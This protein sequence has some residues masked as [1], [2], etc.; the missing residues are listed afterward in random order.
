[1]LMAWANLSYF[2][3]NG[4]LFPGARE[5]LSGKDLHPGPSSLARERRPQ[6]GAA[7]RAFDWEK[8]PLGPISSC[9]EPQDHH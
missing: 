1:M 5:R 3:R 8:T 6:M 2:S 4:G 7:V 9:P